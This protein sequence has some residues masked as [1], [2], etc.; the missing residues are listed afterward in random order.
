MMT[1]SC[2]DAHGSSRGDLRIHQAPYEVQILSEKNGKAKKKLV[3]PYWFFKFVGCGSPTSR[4]HLIICS[5]LFLISLCYSNI[6]PFKSRPH[7]VLHSFCL[8]FRWNPHLFMAS[9]HVLHG[10]VLHQNPHGFACVSCFLMP[11]SLDFW[12]KIQP[13]H[14]PHRGEPLRQA[15]KAR[16]PR[17]PRGPDTFSLC[18]TFRAATTIG[19]S[20][21]LPRG[22]HFSCL[23]FW[24]TEVPTKNLRGD[25]YYG[26]T[27]YYGKWLIIN[28]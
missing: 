7:I 14:Q 24:S 28:G 3:S 10:Q 12:S 9:S 2:W 15:P 19:A 26:N 27:P 20:E 22:S 23:T 16:H 8:D 6:M 11:K 25:P 18:P 17:H 13:K 1:R 21:L 5:W 4:H